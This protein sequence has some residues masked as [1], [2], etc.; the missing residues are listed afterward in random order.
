MVIFLQTCHCLKSKTLSICFVP[1]KIVYLS[2]NCNFQMAEFTWK[3]ITLCHTKWWHFQFYH[4]HLFLAASI[5]NFEPNC[6]PQLVQC[7]W[8]QKITLQLL[9]W[10]MNRK[11]FFSII[12]KYIFKLTVALHLFVLQL[13]K[14]VQW[15]WHAWNRGSELKNIFLGTYFHLKKMKWPLKWK[16]LAENLNW[17]KY[18]Q[19]KLK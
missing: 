3:K 14:L 2:S 7:I 13:W 6:F 10:E 15:N 12:I 5:A 19:S 4:T 11:I 1:S 9:D 17:A 16:F 8:N 18:L